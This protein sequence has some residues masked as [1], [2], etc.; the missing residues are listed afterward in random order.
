MFRSPTR[1]TLTSHFCSLSVVQVSTYSVYQTLVTILLETLYTSHLVRD[2]AL[3]LVHL[4]TLGLL[5]GD[6]LRVLHLPAHGVVHS[7]A[8]S[9]K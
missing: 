9:L 1:G 2:L 6:A 4:V 7:L 3:V 8:L 5:Y